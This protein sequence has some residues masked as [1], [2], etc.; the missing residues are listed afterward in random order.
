MVRLFGLNITKAEKK[1]RPNHKF[2]DWDRIKASRVRKG[3][4]I[5]TKKFIWRDQ[6]GNEREISEK[7]AIDFAE[8]EIIDINDLIRLEIF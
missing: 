8:F 3:Y 2:N 6:E 7:E 1:H 5:H 4:D